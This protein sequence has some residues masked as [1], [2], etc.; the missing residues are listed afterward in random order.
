MKLP[1][2][3]SQLL[4]LAL[5]PH[6]GKPLNPD[7]L[8]SVTSIEHLSEDR[9][10]V[11]GTAQLDGK[12]SESA[13]YY[14]LACKSAAASLEVNHTYKAQEITDDEGTKQLVIWWDSSEDQ[15]KH[16]GF[17]LGCDVELVKSAKR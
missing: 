17:G 11:T 14:V 1:F 16:K 5:F 12:A 4:T 9:Y 6:G 2:L 10:K 13:L 8:L 15:E 7:R 3:I